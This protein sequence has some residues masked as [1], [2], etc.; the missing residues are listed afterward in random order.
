MTRRRAETTRVE[1]QYIFMSMTKSK[2]AVVEGIELDE[3]NELVCQHF[4]LE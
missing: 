2:K 1:V 3:R 4:S